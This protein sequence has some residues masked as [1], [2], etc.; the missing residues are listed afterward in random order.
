[1]QRIVDAQRHLRRCEESLSMSSVPQF[2]IGGTPPTLHRIVNGESASVL[3][4]CGN[5]FRGEVAYWHIPVK[6]IV[7][8]RMTVRT[9]SKLAHV[10]SA[11]TVHLG[12]GR[13]QSTSEI[14]SDR[15]L[16]DRGRKNNCSP[17]RRWKMLGVNSRYGRTGGGQRPT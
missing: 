4:A 5:L 13:T 3:S 17:G 15:D 8:R 1:M 6:Y 12:A 16:G 10:V 11:P 14:S 9:S 7:R 2:A